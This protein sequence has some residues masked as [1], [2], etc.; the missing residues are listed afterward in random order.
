M[1]R[2]GCPNLQSKKHLPTPDG[3]LAHNWLGLALSRTPP[4]AKQLV[5]EYFQFPPHVPCDSSCATRGCIG[6]CVPRRKNFPFIGFRTGV[7]LL[8]AGT[9]QAV[10]LRLLS[11][12]C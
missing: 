11:C 12:S 1:S 8:S 4:S 10:F 3:V 7:L 5:T 2:L 9:G 6:R